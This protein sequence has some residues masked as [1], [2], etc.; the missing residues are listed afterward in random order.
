MYVVA[1]AGHVDHGKS[2]LVRTL[3]GIE[4]DRWAEEQRRGL[5]IDLGFAWT[6]LPSGRDLAF[7]DVPGHERFL[8]NMLAGLG[9]VPVVCFVVAAD[10]GWSAQSDDHRD[11]LAALGI[12]HGLV[13]VTKADRA[14]GAVGAVAAQARRELAGTGLADAPVVAVSA[15]TG[16]GL[17]GL[18]T[19]LD[20]V[21]ANVPRPDGDARVRIWIDR[22]FTVVG[23]GTVVTGTVAAGTVRVGDEMELL[24]A[25][26]T[27]RVTVRGLHRHGAAAGAVGPV[28]RVA[29]NLRGVAVEEV[30]RG[31]A[32]LAPEQWP[33][34]G[35]VDVRLAPSDP[36]E[37][38]PEWLTV[39]AGTA[40][41]PARVRPFD[42]AHARLTL[43]REL[44]LVLGDA[45]V[46]RDPGLKRI[47]GGARVLD[48]D[49]PPL[50]RRGDGA[51]RADALAGRGGD[52]DLLA[53]VA[54]RG[55]VRR[56]RL[57]DLG[58][59]TRLPDGVREIGAWWVH[60]AALDTWQARLR[61]LVADLHERDPLA[62]G[63]SLGAA[64]EGLGL[65][66]PSLLSAVVDGAGL[67]SDGGRL[68]LPGHRTDL[69]PAEP[70]VA[71]L[72]RR[73]AAVPF[74]A[75]DADDL[76][77]LRLGPREL[78]AAE[79]AGRLLRLAE[80]I[81]LTPRAPALAMRE[82]AQLPQPFTVSQARQALG[83][84]RRVAV[85]LLELLDGRGWTRR[86]DAG[87]R[88]VAR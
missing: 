3:T 11:A 49:P 53:E 37:Q 74:A 77:A 21:L 68:A 24:G 27:R 62:A 80:G 2:T 52:G 30:R 23:A 6:T 61:G 43:A 79:R 32:L 31:D 45:L 1:T 56:E 35:V 59:G 78:A 64:R 33:T 55:A 20:A 60:E 72:E 85:P 58:F 71:E 82:L 66:D 67:E 47:V 26:G 13:V 83:T 22:A 18:R 40:A 10:E 57:D 28:S 19:A 4:P 15:V 54:R 44:P 73:L 51:R 9:P 41:V 65:P 12:E 81:V 50:R 46:L 76:A 17:D 39:H 70:A 5:T 14:P 84:S 42:G 88:E 48:A 16:A 38:V 29:V 87:R 25:R 34:T 36:G 8:G 69:G 7:V 75:P 63:L 86:L